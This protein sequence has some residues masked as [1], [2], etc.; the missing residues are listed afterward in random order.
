MSEDL[1]ILMFLNYY[2][3]LNKDILRRKFV[4]LELKLLSLYRK[5]IKIIKLS[6]LFN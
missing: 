4:T 6:I 1:K 3:N 2:Y 5:I